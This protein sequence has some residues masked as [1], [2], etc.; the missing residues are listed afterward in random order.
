ML[1]GFRRSRSVAFRAICAQRCETALG[2]LDCPRCCVCSSPAYPARRPNHPAGENWAHESTVTDTASTN[3]GRT[4]RRICPDLIC[5]RQKAYP[6]NIP[7]DIDGV[8]RDVSCH[9]TVA[10]RLLPE[11]AGDLRAGPRKYHRRRAIILRSG[12]VVLWRGQRSGCLSNRLLASA[13]SRET[14]LPCVHF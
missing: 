1:A 7:A 14:G 10:Y 3:P 2:G 4:A 8:S 5:G 9:T 11:A 6:Q 12:G 13:K